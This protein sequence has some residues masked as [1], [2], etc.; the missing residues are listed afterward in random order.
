METLDHTHR[1]PVIAEFSPATGAREPVEFGVAASRVTGAPLVIVVVVDTG[2]LRAGF[3]AD[4]PSVLPDTIAAEVR[5][6]EQDLTARGVAVEIR[7][8]ED[9]TAARGL[10]R[11]IDECSPEL[12]V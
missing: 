1:G 2:S 6:L 11:A 4:D 12:V 9:S 10:A 7:P 5:R 8:F 3:G